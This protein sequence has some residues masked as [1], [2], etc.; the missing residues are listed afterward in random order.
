MTL[1]LVTLLT[2][3]AIEKIVGVGIKGFAEFDIEVPEALRN[4]SAHR[5]AIALVMLVHG[6][7]MPPH[8]RRFLSEPAIG[9]DGLTN[10]VSGLLV[11]DSLGQRTRRRA[12]RRWRGDFLNAGVATA[13]TFESSKFVAGP[14]RR[15]RDAATQ[16]HAPPASP[17]FRLVGL[18]HVGHRSSPPLP[19]EKHRKTTGRRNLFRNTLAY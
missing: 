17:T 16:G 2:H 13:E 15:D 3:H 7:K 5:L 4:D 18:H 1:G 9:P 19:P 12:R 8:G 14:E 11:D 6:I 10:V